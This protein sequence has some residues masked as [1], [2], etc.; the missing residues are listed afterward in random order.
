MKATPA[1]RFSCSLNPCH[2]SAQCQLTRSL[3]A[4]WIRGILGRFLGSYLMSRFARRQALGKTPWD[5]RVYLGPIASGG[6]GFPTGT[7]LRRGDS[8]RFSFLSGHRELEIAS[9]YEIRTGDIQHVS[10]I[11][12]SDTPLNVANRAK[13]KSGTFGPA[14]LR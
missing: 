9:C 4:T 13:R 7:A 11:T 5:S 10:G 12:N 1:C 8:C 6:V 14:L 2:S 3:A